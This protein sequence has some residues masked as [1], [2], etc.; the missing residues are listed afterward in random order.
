MFGCRGRR[1][2][3]YGSGFDSFIKGSHIFDS[4]SSV[5]IRRCDLL[6]V[7]SKFEGELTHSRGSQYTLL[8]GCGLCC[9]RRRGFAWWLGSR[10][11]SCG[12]L[13]GSGTV[14]LCRGLKD[15]QHIADFRYLTILKANLSNTPGNGRG[16]FDDGFVCLNLHHSLIELYCITWLYEP[17]YDFGFVHTF[18][19]VW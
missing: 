15:D 11:D 6:Q 19:E 8:C 10:W 4:D 14:S 5:G 3:R 9:W 17:L 13:G 7:Y 16:N 18:A 2:R 12:V 1:Y